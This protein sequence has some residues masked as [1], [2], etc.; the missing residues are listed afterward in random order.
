MSLLRL[1]RTLG[2]TRSL[3][4]VAMLAGAAFSAVPAQAATVSST[5]TSLQV[6]LSMPTAA[7]LNKPAAYVL[8][9]TNNTASTLN[10]VIVGQKFGPGA[11]L[12]SGIT[13]LP[14]NSC[15]RG[16]TA[17]ACLVTSLLPGETATLT[18][19][20]GQSVG[21]VVD[22]AAAQAFVGGLFTTSSVTLV[23]DA[24]AIA[25][26]PAPAP[27]PAPAPGGGGGA[28]GGGRGKAA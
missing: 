7:T 14:A 5:N 1:P 17:F 8:T 4:A 6:T 27:A 2:A 18:F 28:G 15:V 16:N 23:S 12:T 19:T 9:V 3:L 25:P 11:R 26:N 24:T 22:T 10:N 13:G 21:S 20:G